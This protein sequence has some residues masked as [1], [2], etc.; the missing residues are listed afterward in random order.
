MRPKARTHLPNREAFILEASD[1][2]GSLDMRTTSILRAGMLALALTAGLT[3]VAPAFAA[4][5]NQA[6]QQSNTGPYDGTAFQAEQHN[7]DTGSN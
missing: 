6:Q 1:I 5:A 3:A 2:K 4:P 7:L